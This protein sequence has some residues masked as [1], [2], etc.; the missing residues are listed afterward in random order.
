MNNLASELA[1]DASDIDLQEQHRNACATWEAKHAE[2]S[3]PAHWRNRFEKVLARKDWLKGDVAKTVVYPRRTEEQGLKL[4]EAGVASSTTFRIINPKGD[5]ADKA[6][7]KNGP[8]GASSDEGDGNNASDN[9]DS[10]F[11][12]IPEAD[13]NVGP[14]DLGPSPPTSP[15]HQLHIPTPFAAEYYSSSSEDEGVATPSK[16]RTHEDLDGA[17]GRP[18]SKKLRSTD[19]P[20]PMLPLPRGGA[21]RSGKSRRAPA[22]GEAKS[23]AV[24][25]PS[26]YRSRE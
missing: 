10:T 5:T 26:K 1:Y 11:I 18:L 16:K 9:L 25:G 15:S 4:F 2:L 23:A 22:S 13:R 24:P 14:P 21:S 20:L 19:I 17:V 7:D 8:G 12:P 6:T 3:S